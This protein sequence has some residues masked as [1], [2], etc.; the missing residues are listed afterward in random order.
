MIG[1]RKED[2]LSSVCSRERKRK[3]T[4]GTLSGEGNVELGLEESIV[5]EGVRAF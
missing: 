4:P 1:C 3:W 2:F 5:G